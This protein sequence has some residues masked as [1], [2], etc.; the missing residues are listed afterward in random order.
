MH[1]CEDKSPCRSVLAIAIG[2]ERA[3]ERGAGVIP[4]RQYATIVVSAWVF[5]A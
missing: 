3:G 5:V 2:N 4:K 1:S